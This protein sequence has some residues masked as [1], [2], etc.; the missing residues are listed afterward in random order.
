M[1]KLEAL[2]MFEAGLRRIKVDLDEAVARGKATD[3]QQRLA[4]HL[5]LRG[6]IGL[7]Q[8]LGWHGLDDVFIRLLVAITNIDAGVSVDWL[9]P[10]PGKRPPP[11]IEAQVVRGRMAG[12]M[13]L[14]IRAGHTPKEAAQ[15]ILDSLPSD[16]PALAGTKA[17]WRTVAQWR[18]NV[19]GTAPP[20]AEREAYQA[21]LALLG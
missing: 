10:T 2:R 21:V 1:H 14:L 15:R 3:E 13:E 6:I 9:A 8:A 11:A 4:A 18:D 19:S 16:H 20:S 17:N 12:V 7:V 5:A